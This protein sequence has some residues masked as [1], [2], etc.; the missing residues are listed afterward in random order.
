MGRRRNDCGNWMQ[1][2]N[3]KIGKL[4]YIKIGPAA[5]D[6]PIGIPW[7]D[8][9]LGHNA[10]EFTLPDGTVFYLDDG[11]WGGIFFPCEPPWYATPYT[12]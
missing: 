10:L 6:Y 7:T 8:W 4:E 12:P 5:W 3:G 2:V 9:W 11:W 1:E